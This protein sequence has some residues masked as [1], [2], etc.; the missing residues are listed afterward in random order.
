MIGQRKRSWLLKIFIV[1][2]VLL[3][4]SCFQE[5]SI[6]EASAAEPNV[7]IDT[8]ALAT[9]RSM[10]AAEHRGS[11]DT[12]A[13][14]GSERKSSVQ[15]QRNNIIS[16]LLGVILLLAGGTCIIIGRNFHSRDK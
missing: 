10:E 7:A 12:K 15:E 13:V 1:L 9:G 5:G 16:L 14:R 6:Q 4:T 8:K 3:M 11:S 2:L